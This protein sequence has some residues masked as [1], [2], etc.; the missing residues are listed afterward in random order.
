M[1]CCSTET[2]INYD[3]IVFSN[4]TETKF[5]SL[6]IEYTLL[7]KQQIDIVMCLTGGHRY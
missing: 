6:L 5:L 2:N 7:W 4:V 3:Q 1:N